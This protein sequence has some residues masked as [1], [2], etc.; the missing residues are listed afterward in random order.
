MAVE[1]T[2]KPPMPD[3]AEETMKCPF[4]GAMVNTGL[5]MGIPNCPVCGHVLEGARVLGAS[6]EDY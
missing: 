2:S 3:N 1:D 6:N 5:I 4:C